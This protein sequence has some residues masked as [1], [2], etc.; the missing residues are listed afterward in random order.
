[1]ETACVGGE[2]CGA[3]ALLTQIIGATRTAQSRWV[4][5][6]D[7]R[8]FEVQKQREA[9]SRTFRT[10]LLTAGRWNLRHD[11]AAQEVAKAPGAAEAEPGT[12]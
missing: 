2:E 6:R 3:R 11:R 10:K 12:D 4:L 1:M 5:L 7:R 9:Q 8:K